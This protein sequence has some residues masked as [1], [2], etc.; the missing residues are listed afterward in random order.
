MN[1]NN[2]QDH[3]EILRKVEKKPKATQRELAK[4]KALHIG[5]SMKIIM[6]WLNGWHSSSCCQAVQ[7]FPCPWG[8]G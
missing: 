7:P 1:K 2:T 6:T 3:F 8:S 4:D 5:D